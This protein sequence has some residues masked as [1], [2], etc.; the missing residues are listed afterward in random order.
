MLSFLGYIIQLIMNPRR[1][2]ED[3]A[4]DNPSPRRML[5][6]GLLPLIVLTSLTYFVRV[7]YFTDFTVVDAIQGAVINAVAY[8]A[9]YFIAVFAISLRIPYMEKDD[10]DMLSMDEASARV[11]IFSACIVGLLLLITFVSNLIPLDISLLH[12]LPLYSVYVI[13]K[14]AEFL[15]IDLPKIGHFMILAVLPIIVP[16]YALGY[17]F[18]LF[19]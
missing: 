6:S 17:F 1:G 11:E 14:G 8:F 16:V 10:E 7:F 18:Y 2:W 15:R 5:M 13:W 4:S 3:V 19:T 9:T 12:Y